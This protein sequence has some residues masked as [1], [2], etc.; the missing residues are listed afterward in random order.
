MHQGLSIA[1]GEE[2]IG[3]PD[4][5]ESGYSTDEYKP[6]LILPE[7]EES[8]QVTVSTPKLCW[9][10]MVVEGTDRLLDDGWMSVKARKRNR[11]QK[12]IGVNLFDLP[13]CNPFAILAEWWPCCNKPFLYSYSTEDL[14]YGLSTSNL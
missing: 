13:D 1:S 8:K 7:V 11:A 6:E 5:D 10:D 9:D 3:E 4:D 2:S 14:V 12:D